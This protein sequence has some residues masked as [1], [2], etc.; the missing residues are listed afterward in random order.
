MS[1][2]VECAD[3]T[4]ICGPDVK[5]DDCGITLFEK[6]RCPKNWCFHCKVYLDD[7][8]SGYKTVW[9]HRNRELYRYAPYRQGDERCT[10]DD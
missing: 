2:C 10:C 8:N 9:K 6:G 4:R 3:G 7:P 5:P 1:D